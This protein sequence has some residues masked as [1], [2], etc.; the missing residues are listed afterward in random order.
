MADLEQLGNGI[1]T[2]LNKPFVIKL[3]QIDIGCSIGVSLYPMNGTNPSDIIQM[4]DE[5]LYHSK[6]T[7]KNRISFATK[8]ME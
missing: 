8:K 5:C 2:K 6:Q 1:I 7:G 3:N 4:A